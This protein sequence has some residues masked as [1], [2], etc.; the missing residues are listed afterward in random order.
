MTTSELSP[1]NTAID[2]AIIGGGPAGMQAALVLA[3]TRKEI[4]V[5]DAPSAPRNG[6]SRGVHNF[7]GLDGLLPSQI[8]EQAWSQIDKYGA[9]KQVHQNVLTIS[10]AD[11]SDDL[12]IHTA[13]QTWSASQVILACGYNDR[14][15]EI[16]GF[17]EC[18]ADSIIPCPF[19]DGYENRD[20][21]WGIVPTMSQML[22]AF[23]AMVQNWT[24]RRMV[25][26]PTDLPITDE[27][28]AM[29]A[30]LD[31]PLH[32]GDIVSINRDGGKVTAVTLDSGE[33]LEVETLLW[34]PP[35][36]A[37]ALVGALVAELGLELDEYGH[38]AVDGMQQTNVAG[39]WATGDAQ[40]SMGALEAAS[41][42]SM[43]AEMIVHQWHAGHVKVAA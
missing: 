19:C 30:D 7:L 12:I 41:T 31:V 40:G 9:A 3:R 35:E 18:W 38:V 33:V 5:F 21:I 42:G 28:Q 32:V 37:T 24:D 4:V 14:F 26:A 1:T 16:E 25:I 20:R 8:R 27:Q 29:M 39:L 15:P 22:D 23:P 17:S 36:E 2:V 11:G 10:R 43:A 13:E 6:A 34:S